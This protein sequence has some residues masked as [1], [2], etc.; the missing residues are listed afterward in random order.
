VLPASANDRRL[1]EQVSPPDWENPVPSDR[2]H[3]VVVGA[4][5]GGLVTAAIASALGA[6]VALVEREMMGGDCL[7]VGCVPSKALLAAGRRWSG[8]AGTGSATVPMSD[9][10]ATSRSNGPPDAA[11]SA[12]AAEMERI[13]EIRA[14]ISAHDSAARF[15]DMGVDVFLGQGE[16][17]SADTLRVGDS[18]LR[19]RRAVVA[20]G[21]RPKVP[22][23]PGLEEAGYRTN[24]TIFSL[25]ERPAR[26][27]VIG[28]GPIGCEL[29]QAFAGLGSEVTILEIAPRLLPLEDPDAAEVVAA[30]LRRD[31]VRVLCGVEVRE[32]VQRDGE[33]RVR[34]VGRGGEGA[35]AASA[36]GGE[37]GADEILVAA[38]R[39]PNVEGI[40]LESA[41]IRFDTASGVEVDGRLRTT[42]RRVYAV[43]D[44]AGTLRFTHLADAHARL[45]V[46]NA[47]FFG[48]GKVEDLVVPWCTYTSPELAHVG[49]PHPELERRESEFEQVT[50]SLADVDRARLD[51]TTSGFARIHL[52]AGTDRIVA[53]TLVGP[54]AGDMIPLVTLAMRTK[55][56]L[57]TLSET[58]FPYPS[59]GEV[60]RKAADQ[61]RRRKLTPRARRAFETF[62][63][64]LR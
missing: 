1:I 28:G 19:F 45:V 61:W 54:H 55:Q 48:R 58:I 62:F 64:V 20:T 12:F 43:G 32:V 38:G 17:A 26:L 2:Y 51:G 44:V 41:G 10:P 33:R 56:G 39:A 40:G 34:F 27:V 29:A 46:R 14:D 59:Y 24:E 18:R 53:A 37:A 63:R 5:T 11:G 50:V 3:L 30:A 57:S 36:E 31:G 16:F 15:R 7:N 25:T 23:I 47:L 8:R 49:M 42:N 60:F 52:E 21:T 4:G 6:R 9:D 13:R 35:S 22:P